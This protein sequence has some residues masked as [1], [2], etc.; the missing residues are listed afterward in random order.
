MK[1]LS[2]RPLLALSVA[3]LLTACG[4]NIEQAAQV[5]TAAAVQ[6]SL[7]TS[8]AVAAAPAAT[9]DAG[10]ASAGSVAVAS[11]PAANPA[12]VAQGPQP[13]CAPQACRGLRIIDGNAEDYRL[14]A[15]RL[16]A[17]D[18]GGDATL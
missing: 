1:L 17:A 11:A 18:N 15:L 12:V 14:K 6:A 4:G 5:Q 2:I 10:A 7:G 9:A 3:T 8:L 16:A 13:D